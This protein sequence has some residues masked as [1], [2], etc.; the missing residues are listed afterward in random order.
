MWNCDEWFSS[1]VA[2]K[3][4]IHRSHKPTQLEICGLL[5]TQLSPCLIISLL[6]R[7]LVFHPIHDLR[8]IRNTYS[9]SQLPTLL[10][11]ISFTQNSTTATLYFL[12]FP[13]LNSVSTQSP[14]THSKFYSS[15]CVQ[16]SKNV[17]TKSLVDSK[18]NRW[19]NIRLSLLH[20][21]LFNPTNL[22]NSMTCVTFSSTVT[23]AHLILSLSKSYRLL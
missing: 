18:L 11:L 2:K 13:S 10:P 19:F 21:I 16:N 7:S 12:I 6:C 15:S 8:R 17:R 22:P 1:S 5:S 3:P 4:I 14:R 20:T 9:T 23:S